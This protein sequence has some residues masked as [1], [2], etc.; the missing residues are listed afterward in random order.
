MS[1]NRLNIQR[2]AQ[3]YR[4]YAA[5]KPNDATPPITITNAT[6]KGLYT[7]HAMASPRADA[8]NHLS[9]ASRGLSV[10]IERV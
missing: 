8:D 9:I 6:S 1:L 7:G 4:L 10:Q 5:T 3:A 2:D